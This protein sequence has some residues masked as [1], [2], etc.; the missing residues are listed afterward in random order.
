MYTDKFST[1]I[2]DLICAIPL[3]RRNAVSNDLHVDKVSTMISLDPKWPLTS[4]SNVV[5][6]SRVWQDNHKTVRRSMA[7][8]GTTLKKVDRWRP[9]NCFYWIR[10]LLDRFIKCAFWKYP[11]PHEQH[12]TMSLWPEE[13]YIILFYLHY[14]LHIKRSPA[15]P[16][17][18]LFSPV[19]WMCQGHNRIYSK[20]MIMLWSIH[21]YLDQG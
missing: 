5:T 11:P 21:D 10:T 18:K 15:I 19:T 14:V 2:L 9:A 7:W 20:K 6:L 3:L 1:H 8:W 16:L 4:S 17:K 12:I 13:F